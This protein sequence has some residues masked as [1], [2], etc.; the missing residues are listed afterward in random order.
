MSKGKAY[1]PSWRYGPNGE[2]QVFERSEDVPLGWTDTPRPAQDLTATDSQESE[3]TY[4]GYTR[5]ALEQILRRAGGRI[6][7]RDTAASIYRRAEKAGAIA[8]EPA[9]QEAVEED[10]SGYAEDYSDYQEADEDYSDAPE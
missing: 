4:G 5:T 10:Y 2:A 9:A 7:A 8:E 6:Y 3:E 1:W